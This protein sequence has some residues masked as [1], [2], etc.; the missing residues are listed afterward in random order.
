VLRRRRRAAIVTLKGKADMQQDRCE[1]CGEITPGYDTVHYGSLDS[2]YRQLC[3]LCFN[4][5]VAELHG[6]DDFENIRLEPV[7]LRDCA[8]VEHRFHF[9]TRLLGGI[10]SLEAF[11]LH[12]GN[13]AGY[14][15]QL[16]GDP[17]DEL[18]ALLGKLIQRI[19]KALSI[20]HIEDGDHGLQIINEMVRGRIEWDPDEDGRVPL[21]VVDGREISWEEFGQIL[22]SHEGSQFKLQIF[23]PSD[24]V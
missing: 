11:E 3:T 9:Q 10:V 21:V 19:R 13:P 20:R 4:A 24:D 15:F 16:I 23:D 18:F 7:G 2:G 8:G 17:E 5:E 6:L 22:M 12:E 14:K 1:K